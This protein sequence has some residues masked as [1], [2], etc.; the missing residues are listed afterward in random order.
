MSDIAKLR[1][2]LVGNYEPDRQISMKLFCDT[3]Q[4]AFGARGIAVERIQPQPRLGR[5]RAGGRELTKWLGHADKFFLFPRE[6]RKKVTALR[7]AHGDAL[8]VH[9]C[10]HSNSMYAHQA[11]DVRHL[12]TCHDLMAVRLALGQMPGPRVRFT[13][14][15][16]QAMIRRGLESAAH[17][18]CIS[19][20]TRNDLHR[21]CDLPESRSSVITFQL[22]HPYRRLAADAAWAVIGPR[23]PN[24]GRPLVLHIGN[25]SWYKN[26]DGVLRIFSSVLGSAAPAGAARPRLVIIGHEMTAAQT[27]FIARHQLAGD[28]VW[29]PSVELKILEAFYSVTTVF[30]FPSLYEGF[31]WPPIEAQACGCP[32]VASTGGA[33]G[34]VVA[35]SALTA[36]TT[37]EAQLARH[38][39]DLLAQPA[40]RETVVARGHANVQRFQPPRMIDGY[41]QR[42]AE[43]LKH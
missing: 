5:W 43:I 19:Q 17:V 40:L 3:L 6:L 11:R 38:V 14:R 23:V 26:R 36:E 35:G 30:L 2:L 29:L 8:I 10:D 1:L 42:Y 13:G 16:L 20:C 28:V 4:G 31:G 34:E 22:N 15:R 41:L 27:E 18:A 24:D 37:D 7:A 39:G 9:V 21:V 25:N 32:V 33:L 12:V